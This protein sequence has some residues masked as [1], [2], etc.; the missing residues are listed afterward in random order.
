MNKVHFIA[1]GGA[2]MHNIALDLH[3]KGVIVSGSDDE[4]YEPSKSLLA[5]K[6]LLPVEF[7]WF[8]EKITSDLDAIVLG[9]HAKIDNPELLKAQE[10]GL[11]I[12]S[13]PE[14]IYL[15]SQ[16]KHRIVIAGSH[17]KT[18]ITA[19]IL[20]VLKF[21]GRD[22]DYMVGA[23]IDGFDTMAKISDAPVIILEGDEYLSS[24]I[25]RRPKFVHY[26]PHVALISG[27]AWDHINVYP[28]FEDYIAQFGN[29]VS[30]ISKA[31]CLIYDETDAEVKKIGES[32]KSDLLKLPYQVHASKIENGKTFLLKK[33][34]NAVEIGV[35]GEHNLKNLMGAK[36]VLEQIGVDEDKFYEAIAS[37]KGA[38]KRLQ[39][40]QET[41]SSAFYLDF[42]HAPSKIEATTRAFKSQFPNRKLV[43]C[44]E[45]HT[46]SSLNKVFLDEYAGKLDS[47]DTAI[48]FFSPNTLKQKN[49][50]TILPSE[51]KNFFKNDNL[52]VFVDNSDL[53]TF[54][55]SQ[56]WT[57]QNLLLMSSGTF[58]GMNL[59]ELAENMYQL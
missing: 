10:L 53:N 30:M 22:F 45:L 13:Y 41:D 59:K 39:L 34:K 19:M 1:I 18:T 7:G 12:Y 2:A 48:V 54:L 57:N 23:R 15:Q 50:E 28:T 44:F 26:R 33:D 35:F 55:L 11:K 32:L 31:G 6:G 38:A 29:L 51:I 20:H 56:D 27:I 17:G 5:A 16:H 4:I 58:G 14:F 8:P 40:I 9:M 25:D 3:N 47:A 46:F 52:L 42:A 21:F 43:A 37:F 49:M 36:L 24:P